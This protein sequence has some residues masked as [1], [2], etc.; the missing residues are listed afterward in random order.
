MQPYMPEET[1]KRMMLLE[2]QN[3]ELELQAQQMDDAYKSLQDMLFKA[4][5]R[6]AELEKLLRRCNEYM[7]MCPFCRRKS[8][9]FHADDCRLEKELS[10]GKV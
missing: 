5:Q 9:D 1:L 2:N 7:A 3:A 10:D 4:E 6:I 8:T